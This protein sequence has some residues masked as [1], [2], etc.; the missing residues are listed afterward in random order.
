MNAR[1]ATPVPDGWRVARLGDVLDSAPGG[2][3]PARGIEDY[4]Q[5]T[6][7][8]ATV[9]DMGASTL[10][11]TTEFITEAGVAASSTRVIP[12][13]TV[14]LA[15]RMAVGAVT[16]TACDTAIN[17][18]LKA[19]IPSALLDGRFLFQFLLANKTKLE[20][21]GTGTTVKGIGMDF[22]RTLPLLV[23]PLQEQRTIAAVLDSIDAAIERTDEVISATDRL[24]D[25]L[26]HELL[27]RGLPGRHTTWRDV[28]GLGSI[29]TC[30]EVVRLGEMAEV[31]MGQS[32]PGS[33]CNRAGEGY[34]LLNGPTE[35]GSVHPVPA[36]WT[37]SPMKAAVRGDL[38]FCVRGA[39]VGRTNW[40]DRDYGIGRGIAAI[41]HRAGSQYQVFLAALVEFRTPRLLGAVAGSTFPNLNSRE[42]SD[43]L[44]GNP[45]LPE[46]RAIAV[47]LHSVDTAIER[48]SAERAALQ[49]SK[50]STMDAL[51]TG[52]VR[53]SVGKG[54]A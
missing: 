13:G 4:W 46:Q 25:A 35:F 6:I 29:P 48:A 31:V 42:I 21:A 1:L 41:R 37:T 39:T 14:L 5:G 23:P 47:T 52:R 32:P 18:D 24:R 15:T 38:L 8:W 40:A 45:P 54:H 20:A 22:V 19:L 36:Q 28:P 16:W 44:I 50:E 43:L 9:K 12:A 7:P 27:T 33:T 30:W 2:G 17:Q 3:T 34:P 10:E 26:L 11:R 49:S 51:L 53:V